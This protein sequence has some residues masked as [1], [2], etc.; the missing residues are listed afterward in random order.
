[1]KFKAPLI[2]A[3]FIDRPNRFLGI[4]KIGSE[5]RQCF[6]PNPGRMMELLCKGVEV[7]L[8]KEEASHRKTDFD[9]V[10]V[11]HNGTLVSID[12]R[13]PNKLL[14]E[15][16]TE[17]KL[18]EF[19]G[20]HVSRSEPMFHDSRFDLLLKNHET[21]IMLEAKSCTLVEEKVALFPD[22]P[23]KRGSRHMLTLI[24]A[25]AYGRTAVVFVI[26]RNDV[27]EFRPYHQ[28]D[29]VFSHSLIQAAENGV[30]IY[31][32]RC[33]VNLNEI[34]IVDRLPVNLGPE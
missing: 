6:I 20:F 4:V 12:S 7:Y 1:M 28:N 29:P 11:N 17:C 24:E 33:R 10:L 34:I 26:Q 13:V 25:L 27:E 19:E 15:A 3:K 5:E 23:T 16:I 31:A 14:H 9:L 32:Y 22:A 30:E 2:P 8:R 18:S 21:Q